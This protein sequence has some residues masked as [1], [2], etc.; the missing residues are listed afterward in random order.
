M[1]PV[2]L[3]PS[4]FIISIYTIYICMYKVKYI[5]IARIVHDAKHLSLVGIN[6]TYFNAKMVV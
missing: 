5:V 1:N 4:D 6:L 2:C 3:V